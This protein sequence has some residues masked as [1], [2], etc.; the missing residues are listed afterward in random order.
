MGPGVGFSFPVRG[1]TVVNS[2]SG[3]FGVGDGRNPHL[4]HEDVGPHEQHQ[5]VAQQQHGV[6]S[7]SFQ[8]E[9][10][11]HEDTLGSGLGSPPAAPR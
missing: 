7:S 2:L 4:A 11:L 8:R 6:P 5:D 9:E 3:C 10:V 1:G